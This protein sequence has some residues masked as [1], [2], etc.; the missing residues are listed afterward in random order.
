MPSAVL[1]LKGTK[2]YAA[3]A[4][5]RL[6]RLLR[7]AS[8][9]LVAEIGNVHDANA[10]AVHLS[11]TDSMLGYLARDVAP[12]YRR[13]VL[14]DSVSSARVNNAE[15]SSWRDGEPRL[16]VEILVTWRDETQSGKSPNPSRMPP[17][18]LPSR[19]GVYAI[20]NDSIARSYIGSGAAPN[21]TGHVA[22]P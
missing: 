20:V 5:Y 6:G 8:V 12:Q 9:E 10:V 14:S 1:V 11:A 16:R 7:G 19:P 21:S 13:R 15:R 4:E 18:D 2:H 3:E 17:G 22:Q